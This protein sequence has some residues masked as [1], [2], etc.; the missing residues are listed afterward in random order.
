MKRTPLYPAHLK[1]NA[2]MVDFA[3]WEMPVQYNSALKE[4]LAVRNSVGLFDVSHMG[5]LEIRGID[6][7]EFTQNL[8]SNDLS[9]LTDGQAQYSTLLYPQGTIVD[10]IIVYRINTD[11]ILICVNASNQD[12]NH[13]WLLEHKKGRVQ[14]QNTSA[15]YAQL[16]LQGPKSQQVLQK[17]TRLNLDLIPY[18]TSAYAEVAGV[19]L[20][21][22]RT[23][24]TGE[25][26]FEFYLP[27]TD[28]LRIWWELLEAGKDFGINAAGLAARN[29]LRLEVSYLLYGNDIDET[30]NVWEAGLDWIVK[31]E[32]DSF[33][34]QKELLRLRNAGVKR[35]LVG[36]EV[37]SRGIA[38]DHYPILID[39]QKVSEISSGSYSPSLKKSIGL[40]YLPVQHANT[41]QVLDI[42]NRG[43]TIHAVVVDTPFF[44]RR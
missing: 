29:T 6:A 33:V 35:K 2:R 18:F 26:G 32:K 39:G 42:D 23:G 37:T 28:A 34:G 1:M 43:R 13:Q 10:D 16:A 31:L 41:G 22:S 3:G 15:E 40:A 44:R 24:Y 9:V 4:H 25:D 38:R 7:L 11:H 20:L 5:Q 19:Q 21:I 36:F 30:T 12:K 8:T 17:L 27:N 14:I